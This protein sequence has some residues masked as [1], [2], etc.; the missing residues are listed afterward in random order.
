MP[1]LPSVRA[2]EILAVLAKF[3]WREARS[4]GSHKILKHETRPGVVVVP[5]HP[6]DVGKSLVRKIVREAGLTPQQFIDAL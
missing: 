2:R 3:G 1:D 6:G 4:V 5:V